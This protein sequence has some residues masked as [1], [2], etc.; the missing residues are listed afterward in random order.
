MITIPNNLRGL[1]E[2][3]TRCLAIC[4]DIARKDGTTL[5]FTSHNRKLTMSGNQY[6]PGG[7]V[8][9]VARRMDNG[10]AEHDTS[11]MGAISSDKITTADLIAKKYNEA[12]VTLYHVDWRFCEATGPFWNQVYT[13]DAVTFN[14]DDWTAQ[15]AS[16]T[17]RLNSPT[18]DVV[19]RDCDAVF[20]DARCGLTLATFTTTGIVVLG[21]LDGERR[22]IIRATSG[23]LGAFADDTF[24]QGD[25]TFT[26]GANA[27]V[28]RVVKKSTG[29]TKDFE[30]QTAFPNDIAI[31][32]VFSATVGCDGR[33]STCKNVFNNLVNFRGDELVGGMDQ[34]LRITPH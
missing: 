13:A 21:M 10:A 25:I 11:A 26:S 34:V 14:G 19:S 23:S 31:G 2:R 22:R 29:A 33:A 32:D 12:V 28:K 7:K 5:R 4:W 24:A 18:G 9:G 3:N 16:G 17:R 20:C 8:A 1:Y 15:L 30:L 27:G 6:V